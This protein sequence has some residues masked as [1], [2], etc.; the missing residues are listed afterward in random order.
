MKE[1]K[2][3]SEEVRGEK[4]KNKSKMYM[5]KQIHVAYS[6]EGSVPFQF[7]LRLKKLKSEKATT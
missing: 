5:C 3:R 1:N 4:G 2:R 6:T 7:K